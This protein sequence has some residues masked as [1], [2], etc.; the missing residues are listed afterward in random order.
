MNTRMFAS[1]GLAV[2]FFAVFSLVSFAAEL[3]FDLEKATTVGSWQEKRS[4][5]TDARGKKKVSMTKI[6]IVGEEKCGDATCI[7]MEMAMQEMNGEGEKAKPKGDRTIMKILLERGAF[8]DLGANLINNFKSKAKVMIM[9]SGKEK[10]M[11]VPLGENSMMGN[12]MGGMDVKANFDY[13]P[14][15]S[16]TVKTAAGEFTANKYLGTG[17]TSVVFFGKTMT[18]ESKST[19]WFDEKVPFGIVKSVIET[20]SNQKK[21]TMEEE[22]ISF[23][24]SGA[25]SEI[26]G[27]VEE[28]PGFPPGFQGK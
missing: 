20:V 4:I 8:K 11:K 13:Q 23:G 18:S 1:C 14:Q 24:T 27:P 12:L 3:P 19:M 5:E 26:T 7:W 22:I 9:K 21:T 17:S 6:S 2:M 25:T 28:M 16:E 10:P 15:G